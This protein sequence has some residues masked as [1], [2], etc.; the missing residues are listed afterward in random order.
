MKVPNLSDIPDISPVEPGEYDLYIRQAKDTKSNDGSR[1]GLML[2]IDIQ[3]VENA[4]TI[5][6]TI[7][8]PNA[9]DDEDKA[10]MMW[11]MIKERIIALGLDPAEENENSD[12]VGISFTAKLGVDTYQ[13]KTKNIIER[14]T[15]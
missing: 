9:S 6:D 13:G 3:G 7:W 14:I 2:V 10:A 11:R 1:E 4:E 5:F 8:F 15:G 12:F